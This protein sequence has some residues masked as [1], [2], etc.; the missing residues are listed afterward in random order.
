MGDN[1][2]LLSIPQK[3]LKKISNRN[4]NNSDSGDCSV[5]VNMD[6]SPEIPSKPFLKHERNTIVFALTDFVA[7]CRSSA[8]RTR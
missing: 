4:L 5:N 6:S 7:N 3:L 1:E 2:K 8:K